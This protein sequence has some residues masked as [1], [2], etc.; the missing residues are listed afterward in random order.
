MKTRVIILGVVL[1]FTG[2]A[3]AQ[4]GS[5]L[6]SQ[7]VHPGNDTIKENGYQGAQTCTVC[8]DGVLAEI[9]GTVHWTLASPVK[10]VQ[11]LPDGTWWGMANRECALAGSTDLANWTAST[12]GRATVQAAGCG[13]CH[14]GSLASPPLPGKPPTQAE[15][16]TVDCLVCHAKEYDWQKRA[17]LVK[18]SSGVHWAQD[19][20]LKAALSVTRTPTTEACLRCHEH[21]FSEDYKRGTPYTAENDVHA[22]AGLSCLTCHVSEHHKIAKGQYESDMVAN[23][24][25][26]VAIGCT[27]CHG[28]APHHG[29][30]AEVLNRHTRRLACQTC[31]ITEVS[32]IVD[33]DWG[34][35]VRDDIHGAYSALSK[36]DKIH[37][38]AGLYVP[39]DT[40]RK[41]HPSYIWRVASDGSN[42]DAQSWMAFQ[43]AAITTAG[44]MI[45]P[46]RGLTQ[47]MLFDRKLKMAQAPGMAF[48]NDNPQMKDFPLLLAPN[49]EVYNASGD[50]KAAIDAGMRPLEAIGLKWSGEW[51]AM[52]VP[53]TSYISVNHG[54]RKSGLSC[55]AC[56]STRGV[57]DF[58][59]LGYTE[60]Q[61]ERLQREATRPGL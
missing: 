9:V 30:H 40:I 14:I 28:E 13:L 17:T 57:M 46:V 11:G 10:N 60:E 12:G 55:N 36:Y 1:S 59:A 41:G 32:G 27:T 50:V 2:S 6:L 23:D 3:W 51:M 58:K 61:V 8:H 37:A 20:S 22:A 21:S 43:T 15:T 4:P 42:K 16:N 54:V 7:W 34:K 56:H 38:I 45:F 5:G 48:L 31:H 33:E 25:P 19:T 39:T 44:A 47:V 49:R 53:G 35:P 24:L 26:D 29:E 18:D 52:E